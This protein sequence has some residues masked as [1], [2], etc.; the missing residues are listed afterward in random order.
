MQPKMLPHAPIPE[1]AGRAGTE[2]HDAAYSVFEE[3]AQIMR[4][5]LQ[6]DGCADGV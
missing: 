1:H 3:V 5:T 2:P 6:M 4:E